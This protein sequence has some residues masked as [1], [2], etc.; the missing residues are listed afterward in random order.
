MT[1]FVDFYNLKFSIKCSFRFENLRLFKKKFFYLKVEIST[2]NF[3]KYRGLV[4]I[5]KLHFLV[6][7]LLEVQFLFPFTSV[8]TKF[9][10]QLSCHLSCWISPLTNFLDFSPGRH[11]MYS[12]TSKS[13]IE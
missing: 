10:L 11:K 4:A 1:E 2:L 8:V 13:Y 3:A 5:Y 9:I 7:N 12:E 6:I